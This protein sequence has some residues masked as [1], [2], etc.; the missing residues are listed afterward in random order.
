ML[1]HIL[2]SD[3]VI[4]ETPKDCGDFI[5]MIRGGQDDPATLEM[6]LSEMKKSSGLPYTCVTSCSFPSGA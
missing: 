5:T 1:R 6:R 4:G 3:S 2:P